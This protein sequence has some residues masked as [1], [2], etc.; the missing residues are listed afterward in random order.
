MTNCLWISDQK[1]VLTMHRSYRPLA[2]AQ[3]RILQKKWDEAYYNQHRRRVAAVRPQIDTRP[4][5]TYM[6]LH[7]KLKKLQLEEER[8]AVIERDNRNLLEKMS[9]IMR[10][11]GK[12]DN[13]NNN[14]DRRS[15]NRQRRL[16][17]LLRIAKE[18]Q[19]ILKRITLSQPQYDHVQWEREW[20]QNLQ[21]MDQISAYPNDWWK[22]E[23]PRREK[24]NANQR[25]K[26]NLSQRE[27]SNLSR[28]EKS[29]L[30]DENTDRDGKKNEKDK[31]GKDGSPER[32]KSTEREQDKQ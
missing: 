17:E 12:I 16:R 5:Q 14:Y 8:L 19:D 29:N 2:P 7:L 20:H 27:K 18:N 25:E 13:R 22:Q 1:K 10:T 28:R 15:L 31:E 3:S 21:L 11:S 6:H 26:S 23:S 9:S 4:P 24:T 32:E 30:S